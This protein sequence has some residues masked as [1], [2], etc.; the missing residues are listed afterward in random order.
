MNQ[1]ISVIVPIYK[2]EQYL[3]QCIDSILLQTYSNLEIILVDDG[4]PDNCGKICDEYADRDKRIEVIHKQNGGLSDARNAGI[5]CS[6]GDYLAF[7]DSDDWIENDML[8]ILLKNMI[9][10]NADV[11]TCGCFKSYVNNLN[12]PSVSF[13]ETVCFNKEQ[14]I[15]D[16]FTISKGTLFPCNK[17]YKKYIFNDLRFPKGKIYEGSATIIDIYSKA[18]NIVV[19]TTPKY[20]YRQRKS[21]IVNEKFNPTFMHLIEASQ[22]NFEIIETQYPNIVDIGKSQL[23]TRKIRLLSKIVFCENFWEIPE[24]KPTLLETQK[25]FLYIMKSKHINKNTKIKMIAL[26]A[27][28]MLFKFLYIAIHLIENS[29]GK[30]KFE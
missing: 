19:S 11:S 4:S 13:I 20:Y 15:S 8:E 21:S 2:V 26:R 9:T 6:V 5:D 17:L 24:Y 28:V 1:K 30:V 23:L 10:Y 7:I 12:I 27:N 16:A 3:H 29:K 22:R 18:N 25:N 14:A